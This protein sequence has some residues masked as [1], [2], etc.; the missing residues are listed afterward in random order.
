M[1]GSVLTVKRGESM[2][3]IEKAIKGLEYHLKELSVGKTCFGCPYCGDNPCEIHLISD[4]LELLKEQQ[5][6]INSLKSDLQETLKVV[7]EQSNVIRCKDCIYA[8]DF[9]CFAPLPTGYSCEKGHGTH[10]GDWY[11]ADGE[12]STEV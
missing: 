3:D 2:A 7:S 4:A 5:Q 1:T 9:D 10:T 8:V 11:C 12:Q 6:I